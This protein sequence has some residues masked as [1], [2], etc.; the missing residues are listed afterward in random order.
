MT[1]HSCSPRPYPH[2]IS[3][4]VKASLLKIKGARLSCSVYAQIQRDTQS[5]ANATFKRDGLQGAGNGCR[6]DL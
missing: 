1:C 2:S 6:N 3:A 5:V 4:K